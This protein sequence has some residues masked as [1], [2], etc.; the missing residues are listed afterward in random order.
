MGIWVRAGFEWPRRAAGLSLRNVNFPQPIPCQHTYSKHSGVEVVLRGRIVI[1]IVLAAVLQGG[2]AT[3]AHAL[4]GRHKANQPRALHRSK[5]NTSPY[6][7]L[8]P[9][10]HKKPNG[11]YRSTLTGEMVY[12][13]QKKKK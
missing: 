5:K 6:A 12:G 11:Y 8:A 10:K 7:Y 4:F 2:F 9:K 3:D 1:P 13:K